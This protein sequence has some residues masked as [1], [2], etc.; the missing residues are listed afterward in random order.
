MRFVVFGTGAIG[1]TI[2]AALARAGREVTAI[3]RGAQLEALRA[4]GLRLR[5]PDEDVTVRFP[6]CDSPAAAGIGPGDAVLLTMKGQDTQPALEALRAA[7][8]QD[9]PIFCVQNGVDNERKALRLF[10]N[11]HAVTVIMPAAFLRPGEVAVYSA[12]QLGVFDVG[13]A[14]GGQDGDDA[15]F[16][17]AMRAGNIACYVED[18]AMASKYGKLLLNLGNIVGAAFGPDVNTA[19]LSAGLQKEAAAVL[20]AAGIVW[21][22]LG[23]TDPRRTR[24]MKMSA[25]SGVERFGSSTAQSLERGTGSIETDWLNGE[26]VLL[27]RLH[28]VKAP[29]N[30]AVTR[31]AAELARSGAPPGSLGAD[32]LEALLASAG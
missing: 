17:E 21:K 19:A 25:V 24:H 10:A 13:R 26:I 22:D 23:M 5:T 1:G 11:V 20:D 6:V 7:G 14:A 32:R 9:Q 16:A 2:A 4:Q 18:D 8:V 12:P 31:L 3:A 30:A 28:G 29:L 15:A 27:G